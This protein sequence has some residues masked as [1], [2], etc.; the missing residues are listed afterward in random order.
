VGSATD[1]NISPIPMPAANSM[2]NHDITENSGVASR[3][4]RRIFPTGR[5]ISVTQNRTNTLAPA[6]N[7]QSK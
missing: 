5:K 7:S 1:Q 2:A 4:P 3:P 6:M